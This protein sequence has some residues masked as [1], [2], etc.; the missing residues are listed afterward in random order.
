[1]T[2]ECYDRSK[3]LE[4]AIKCLRKY[5]ANDDVAGLNGSGCFNN[6]TATIE[7]WIKEIERLEKE[8]D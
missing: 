8:E 6:P 4:Y 3:A 1:M 5:A 7:E 2:K